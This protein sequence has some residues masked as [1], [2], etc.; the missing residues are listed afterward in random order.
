MKRAKYVET[1][2]DENLVR[3]FNTTLTNKKHLRMKVTFAPL[4]I[5]LLLS[6]GLSNVKGENPMSKSVTKIIKKE[7]TYPEFAKEQ[8]LEGVVLVSFSFNEDGTININTTNESNVLLKNY[9]VEK[10]QRI[11]IG[12]IPTDLKEPYQVKFEF[13]YIQ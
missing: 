4:I 10:L 11:S 8:K 1:K 2:T 3:E 9:V 6:L 13:K 7:I 12:A 5:V